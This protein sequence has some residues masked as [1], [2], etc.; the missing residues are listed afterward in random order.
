MKILAIIPAR[1]GSKRIKQKNIKFFCGKEMIA[2]SIEAAIKSG[3]FDRIIV[4]TDDNDIIDVVKKHNCDYLLRS[5]EN[6][7]DESTIES[8]LFEVLKGLKKLYNT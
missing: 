5:K 3:C 6:A 8:V 4:S 7:R 1:A 2:W